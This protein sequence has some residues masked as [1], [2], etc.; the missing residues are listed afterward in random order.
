M[1]GWDVRNQWSIRPGAELLIFLR[2]L[3]SGVDSSP[4]LANDHL[5]VFES[6]VKWKGRD[7]LTWILRGCLEGLQRL[8]EEDAAWWALKQGLIDSTAAW[9][10]SL[11]R[12]AWRTLAER[13]GRKHKWL[14]RKSQMAFSCFL[15]DWIS[16][17]GECAISCKSFWKCTF[18]PKFK[19]GP[20]II[21]RRQKT[22]SS[23]STEEYILLFSAMRN[24]GGLWWVEYK[25][26]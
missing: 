5:I 20:Q 26:T 23:V 11:K 22:I 18:L 8:P 14:V 9:W 25:V 24:Y 19:A 4:V 10:I 12:E 7:S 15:R 21:Y 17:A 6:T 2:S 13:N 3:D 16:W 1:F